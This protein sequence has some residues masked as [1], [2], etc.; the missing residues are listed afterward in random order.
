MVF[1]TF[2]KR[3]VFMER[4]LEIIQEQLHL[5][6]IT[7]TEDLSFQDDLGTDSVDL[8]ELIM[9]LEDEYGV[10]LSYEEIDRRV[11]TISDVI[12]YLRE[13]GADI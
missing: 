2:I 12:E 9:A 10:E 8:M 3:S 6:G 4:V 11:R 5:S 7:I 1:M 13:Q